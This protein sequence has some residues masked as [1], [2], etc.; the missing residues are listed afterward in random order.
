M[1]TLPIAPMDLFSRGADVEWDTFKH[2][3][4][5]DY[6][7]H[8]PEIL[9]L[10]VNAKSGTYD[11]VALPNW[12]T[13]PV[14]KTLSVARQLGLDPGESFV[15]FDFWNQKLL[16]VVSDRISVEIEGHDTRVVL[17]HPCLNRPQLVGTSRHITGA[18]SIREL[19]WD[20]S[21]RALQGLSDTVP[22]SDYTLFLYLPP[23]TSPQAKPSAS[24]GGSP[25]AVRQE[26]NGN[27]LSVSFNSP[28]AP[29]AWKVGF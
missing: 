23:G 10:K 24:A 13:H 8:Y 12:R 5:D 29:V 22:G 18:L 1:P 19:S 20:A 25:V 3:S 21:S 27:L 28:R 16:G 15:A 4:T 6:I 2:I 7:Q 11:V 17:L 14:T 9:D 26:Q